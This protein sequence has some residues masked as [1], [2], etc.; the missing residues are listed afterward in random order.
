MCIHNVDVYIVLV[1]NT[2]LDN[3]LK[4]TLLDMEGD[5]HAGM[6]ICMQ[7]VCERERERERDQA[8]AELCQVLLQLSFTLA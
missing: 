5:C 3:N 2:D 8:G 4:V 1:C 7:C 6:D